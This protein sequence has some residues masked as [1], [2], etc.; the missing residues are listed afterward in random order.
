MKLTRWQNPSGL[1]WPSLG[2]LS[3]LHDEFERLFDLPLLTSGTRSSAWISGWT[4]VLDVYEDKDQFV[5]KAELPGMKQEDIEV[6]LHNAT[7]TVSGERKSEQKNKDAG[8][9]RS[10]RYFGRFQRSVDL[11]NTVDQ[12]RVKADYKDGILTIALPKTE[13]AKPKRISV[14]VK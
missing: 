13:E 9:Y 12:A 11:P 1:E 8:V 6:S 4:P 14:S 10:E 3:E 5:V 2:Q 7:L